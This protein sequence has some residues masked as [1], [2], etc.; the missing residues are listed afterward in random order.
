MT[1]TD[2]VNITHNPQDPDLVE[3]ASPGHGV[4]S[5]EPSIAAQVGMTAAEKKPR[6]FILIGGR[7]GIGWR[8]RRSCSWCNSGRSRGYFSGW[9]SWQHGG[10]LRRG[11]SCGG[12]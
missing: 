2:R 7:W 12:C 10:S 4:P 1:I 5:Q 8:C 9:N 6:S 11:C 3:Q